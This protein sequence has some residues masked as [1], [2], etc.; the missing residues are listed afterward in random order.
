MPIADFSKEHPKP[1][2]VEFG[3]GTAGFRM[4][5]TLLDSVAF[6]VGI[7]AALRSQFKKG[8]TIGVMITASHN[9]P[10]DNGVKLV[11]PLGSMLEASWEVYAAELAN[12]PD[13]EL[14]A[15]V[16]SLV[17]KLAIDTSVRAHVVIGR[18]S[19]ESGPALVASL[20]DGLKAMNANY[21]NYGLL[22]TPQLHY[23]TR[24]INTKG[25]PDAYGAP[26]EDGYYEKLANALKKAVPDLDEPLKCVV[27]CANG[28]G[29]PKVRA[30]A[31][32]LDGTLSLTIVNDLYKD[33]AKLNMDCG[34]D[35]VKTGQRLP[36]GVTPE[37][38]QLLA[39]FDG[40]ADRIVFSYIDD[41][42]TFHL[43]D[44]DKIAT[45]VGMYI[46]E[47]SKEA[48]L[49]LSVGVVQTAYANGSST[50]YI[51]DNLKVPV[52]CTPTGVKHLHHAAE[53][54][55][56]GIYFE[57]NGH[58]TVLFSPAAQIKLQ[59]APEDCGP[60]QRRA[61]DS[62]LALSDLINQTVGDAISD[63]LLVLVVLS[64]NRW[65]PEEWDSA[66]K[67]L[68]NRLDKVVVKDRSIFKTTDA[69]R[70]LTSPPG[71]QDKIDEVVK[72]F[73]QGRSFV[74]A[75][76]TEDAVRV[77]AEAASKGEADS[78]SGRVSQFLHA[79]Q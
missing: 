63:L 65:G 29:A 17:S 11:D 75:S 69:E 70:R 3:Y 8:Q 62:L 15:K 6:R 73:N 22:T 54:F 56:I 16:D 64:I 34:A 31:A 79:F 26:T 71:L 35:Y 27:D 45:L 13:N 58:G 61:I 41:K 37:P 78:L 47:L 24:A 72:M 49:D 32:M 59:T 68:P 5:A 39:S 23:I 10:P 7:L 25:T 43:L 12:A 52:V 67:D 18:D 42:K 28:I 46:T 60:V 2:G 74:R 9:P 19:R 77:Y 40:D 14:Q 48:A 36:T 20:E 1:E 38:Y 55:D 57:A 44:G 66:Y 30:L 51:V 4:K 21:N 33:P 53:A 76:G 50:K